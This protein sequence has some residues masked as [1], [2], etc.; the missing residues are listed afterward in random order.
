[1]TKR[2]MIRTEIPFMTE[3]FLAARRRGSVKNVSCE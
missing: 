3:T 1:M 2:E